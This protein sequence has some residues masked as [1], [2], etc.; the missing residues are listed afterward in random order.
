[1]P[2]AVRTTSP[3]SSLVFYS[4]QPDQRI[5]KIKPL[6]SPAPP[7]RPSP[8]HG[9]RGPRAREALLGAKAP[10]LLQTLFSRR[11]GLT[12]SRWSLERGL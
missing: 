1:M 6:F 9:D 10:R 5:G 3:S 7:R 11:S 12:S 2:P 8:P 4:K